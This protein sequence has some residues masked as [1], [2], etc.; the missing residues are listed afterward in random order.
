M[1]DFEQQ[2]RRHYEAQRLSD[3]K[4]AALLAKGNVTRAARSTRT[5]TWLAAA[6]LALGVFVYAAWR[7]FAPASAPSKIAMSEV[8]AAV[9]AHFSQP[10]YRLDL[11]SSEPAELLAWLQREGAPRNVTLPGGLARLSSY[12]CQVLDVRGRRAYLICFFLDE[13]NG[14]GSGD[15]PMREMTV[16]AP[17][18]TMMKKDRPLVHF[19]VAE[20]AA[21]EDLPAAGVWLSLQDL[22]GWSFR[23]RTEGEHV[24]LLASNAGA[25][26]LA[27]VAASL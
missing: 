8:A 20:G 24:F 16:T 12:G 9:R 15:A 6:S 23:V 3:A 7:S 2:L 17:D 25:E 27:E 4:V 18:G 14:G 13:A 11:V 21:Y 10:G 22:D 26:R 1:S 19:V 5:W